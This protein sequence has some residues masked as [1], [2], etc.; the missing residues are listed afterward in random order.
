MSLVV[1]KNKA[2]DVLY[3]GLFRSQAEMSQARGDS[4]L[5]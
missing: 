3:I 1:K 4:H 5:I 2:L